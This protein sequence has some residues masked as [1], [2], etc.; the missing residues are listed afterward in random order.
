MILTIHPFLI[1]TTGTLSFCYREVVCGSTSPLIFI[2]EAVIGNVVG[3]TLFHSG[4]IV[5]VR[6]SGVVSRW[7]SAFVCVIYVGL[8]DGLDVGLDDDSLIEE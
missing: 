5:L 1:F 8:H 3:S 2:D 7:I 6:A 4:A